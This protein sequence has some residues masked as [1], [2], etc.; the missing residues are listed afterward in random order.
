M[1]QSFIKSRGKGRKASEKV[2]VGDT[3]DKVINT[4][5]ILYDKSYKNLL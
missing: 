1:T 2:A 4:L 5:L 3:I